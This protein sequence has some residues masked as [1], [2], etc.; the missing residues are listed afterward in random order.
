MKKIVDLYLDRP[1]IF[2]LALLFFVIGGFLSFDSLPRQENP[3]LA[4][5]WGDITAVLPGASPDRV[6]TQIADVLETELR[7][8][9]E[10]KRLDSNSS[11]GVGLVGIE[12]KETVSKAQTDEI[13]SKIENKLRETK[14][15]IPVG[16]N[17]SL[18]HSGPPTT[19]LFALQWTGEGKPQMIILSRLASQSVSYTHLTLPTTPY[20]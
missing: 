10:I 15:L 12:L 7:E 19:L 17:L 4:E 18:N 9:D 16:T 13:W 2:I 1:R 20:V 8:I 6:E 11:T 5:R 3:Q 14:S